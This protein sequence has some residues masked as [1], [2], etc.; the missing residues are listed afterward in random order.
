MAGNDLFNVSIEMSMKI[1]VL[2][3]NIIEQQSKIHLKIII[4]VL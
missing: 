2:V 3:G 1:V 4:V